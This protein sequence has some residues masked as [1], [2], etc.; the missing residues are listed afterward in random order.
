M[1]TGKEDLVFFSQGTHSLGERLA[2]KQMQYYGM[3]TEVA[4]NKVL[5][6]QEAMERVKEGFL[7]GRGKLTLGLLNLHPLTRRDLVTCLCWGYLCRPWL[8]HVLVKTVYFKS[9]P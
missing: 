3:S 7:E 9:C 5:G 6:W 8:N 1:H 4:V 2:H